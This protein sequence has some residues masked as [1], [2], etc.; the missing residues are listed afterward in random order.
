MIWRKAVETLSLVILPLAFTF[1]ESQKQKVKSI[2]DLPRHTYEVEGTLVELLESENAY[3]DFAAG[4]RADV[5][6][7]LA[8]Y[9]FEDKTTLKGLIR[10]LVRLDMFEGMYDS[11]LERMDRIR[12]LE[13]K[14]QRRLL[15]GLADRSIIKAIR[16][17]E[18]LDPEVYRASFSKHYAEALS[19]L[20]WEIVG[21]A[22]EEVKGVTEIQ[23]RNFFL[24]ILQSELEPA[25]AQTGQVSG[26]TAD[27]LTIYHHIF[28]F[29]IPIRDEIIEVL[30]SY[31]DENKTVKPD[32]WADR[33]VDLNGVEGL[34]PVTLAIWDT[35]VDIDLF[36][37]LLFVNENEI[38]NEKDDDGNGF[39]DDIHGIAHDEEDRKVRELLYPLGELKD[40]LPE[41]GNLVKGFLDVISGIDSPEASE[42][43]TEIGRL[44][45]EEFE[46]FME[47]FDRFAMYCHGTH[48]ADVAVRGNPAARILVARFAEDYHLIPPLPT[49][50]RSLSEAKMYRDVVGYFKRSGVRVVN[51]SWGGVLRGTEE[52]LEMNGFG[53]NAEERARLARKLFDVEKTALYEAIRGAP[54]ILFVCAA[55]NNDDDVS[56]EDYYPS[57]F[58]LSNILTVGAVDQAGDETSFTSFGDRV[59]V[60]ANGYEVEGRI[61]GGDRMTASGTSCSSPQV[62]NLAAKLLAIDPTLTP[63]ELV[64]LIVEG[65]DRSA[66]GRFL[67]VNPEGSMEILQSKSSEG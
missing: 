25:V 60:Y 66:D 30:S 38:V 19:E 59:K 18:S 12:D 11:A 20:P 15:S 37:G 5:E 1:G 8:T 54:E 36:P 9:D 27:R 35:G 31:I 55:G 42:L 3:G 67:L 39:V 62:V 29:R 2:D 52:D 43:R 40:R 28:N 49:M 24:G 22:V 6:T 16:E 26:E 32:I 46:P 4:L 47:D 50:E 51:M 10:I 58:D 34:R 56:F 65:S 17:V 33:Q 64:S 61:P 48:V 14:P 53:E 57:S 21:E 44:R 41:V 45:P 13:E 23:T 63:E 7:D